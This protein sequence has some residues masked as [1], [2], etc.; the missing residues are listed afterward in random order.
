MKNY[1]RSALENVFHHYP[2]KGRFLFLLI[3]LLILVIAFPFLQ[4][5]GRTGAVILTLL[6]SIIP[7][8]G[9]YGVS[10]NRIQFIVASILA[11]P[12]IIFNW[13]HI[14]LNQYFIISTS[15]FTII[16]YFYAI[17]I[18]LYYIGKTKVINAET[19]YGA[20]S[21][22]LLIGV[23]WSFGYGLINALV[24]GS[25]HVGTGEL[26]T[27][28]YSFVTL[29]TLGYGDIRPISTFARSAAVV[30]AIIGILYIAILVAQIVGSSVAQKI[31]GK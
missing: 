21:V 7:L 10:A 29:T 14:F 25:F 17:I 13:L 30:E 9:V 20:V 5:W 28:Y 19:I 15:V 8:A 2:F 22:Y 27:L 31:K 3:S 18:I 12:V 26:N 1:A 16:F 24:P 23:V 4:E 6:G 11:A